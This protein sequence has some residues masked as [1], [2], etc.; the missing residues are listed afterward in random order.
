MNTLGISM[1]QNYT[2][3]EIMV[4]YDSLLAELDKCVKDPMCD[5][6]HITNLDEAIERTVTYIYSHHL[7]IDCEDL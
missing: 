3:V 2:M 5:P 4:I 6:E 1:R 7:G